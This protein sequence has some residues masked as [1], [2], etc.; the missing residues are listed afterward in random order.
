MRIDED[1]LGQS[2]PGSL[3]KRN[4][5]DRI[6]ALGT[7]LKDLFDCNDG[8]Q[9]ANGGCADDTYDNIPAMMYNCRFFPDEIAGG[10]EYNGICHNILN[11][12]GNGIG[13]YKAEFHLGAGADTTNRRK[14]CGD[15]GKEWFDLVDE[16]GVTTKHYHLWTTH[17]GVT[18]EK[19]YILWEGRVK[20]PAANWKKVQGGRTIN[21]DRDWNWARNNRKL[22]TFHLFN[23]D[24]TQTP[25]YTQYQVFNYKLTAGQGDQDDWY[26]VAGAVN[27]FGNPKY[28][29]EKNAWCVNLEDSAQIGKDLYYYHPVW[30][31]ADYKYVSLKLCNVVFDNTAAITKMKRGE[32]PTVEEMFN[33][34]GVIIDDDEDSVDIPLP[35]DVVEGLE[36]IPTFRPLGGSSKSDLSVYQESLDEPS[37]D[38]PGEPVDRH[39]A[40]VRSHIAGGHRHR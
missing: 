19:I 26:Y 37:L 32:Q 39:A 38:N 36:E 21:K 28:S 4:A 22:F 7:D 18:Q 3:G 34:T 8:G 11:Y 6:A 10:R 20:A 2:G 14:V 16:H 13:P 15:G 27:T 40:H 9:C 5:A 30:Q 1:W 23:S 35:L 25:T 24:T 12:F 29:I 17:V 31:F 33:I